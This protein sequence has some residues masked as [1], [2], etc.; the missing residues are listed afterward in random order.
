MNKNSL[1]VRSFFLLVLLAVIFF[2]IKIVNAVDLNADIA[3]VIEYL[4]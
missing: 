2:N 4:I 1:A 3:Y